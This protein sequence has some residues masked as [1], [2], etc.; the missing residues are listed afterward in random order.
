MLTQKNNKIYLSLIGLIKCLAATLWF[1]LANISMSLANEP[2]LV[3][4]HDKVR[5]PMAGYLSRAVGVP[6]EAT[7]DEIAQKSEKD[8]F[9]YLPRLLS[10]GYSPIAHWYRF[11]VLRTGNSPQDWVLA[12]GAPVINDI[13]VYVPNA[14]G[15]FDERKL[16]DHIPPV[17]RQLATRRHAATFSLPPDQPITI[18]VRLV[19]NS[20]LMFSAEIWQAEALIGSESTTSFIHGSYFGIL[21]VVILVYS[22]F[23]LWLKDG[24]LLGYVAYV[25]TLFIMNLGI[26]GFVPVI[27]PSHPYW[28]PDIVTGG[29]TL[30]SCI[31]PFLMWDR[32]LDMRKNFPRLHLIYMFLFFA[33]IPGVAFIRTD[34][35]GFFATNYPLIAIVTGYTSLAFTL[36]VIWRS[37]FKIILFLYFVAFFVAT[38]AGTFRMMLILGLV[39][40]TFATEYSFQ[41][42]SIV[43][44]LL[45]SLALAY[46]IREIDRD[47][48]CAREEAV[49]SARR[50]EEQ[51]QFVGMLSHEFRA[52]LANIDKATQM[53]E[54]TVKTMSSRAFEKLGVIRTSAKRLSSMVDSF[55]GAEALKHGNLALHRERV[56][57]SEIMYAALLRHVHD[58]I[59]ARLLLKIE[60]A[61]LAADLDR[62]MMETAISNLLDNA[63]RYSPAGTAIVVRVK[64]LKSGLAISI[65]DKGLGMSREEIGR[66]GTMYFR[67]Q[68][69][70]G[71][72]GSGLGLHMVKMIAAAHGG[73]C[74]IESQIG[75]GTIVT[76]LL[77][78]RAGDAK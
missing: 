77:P 57:L 49:I 46:R 24:A 62:D 43:H 67:A 7:I 74:E 12:L 76:L 38:T 35:Y 64:E 28:L 10:G 3:L 75:K 66:V 52:P 61:E 29:G 65:A 44:I 33:L 31:T 32:F 25:S 18:Y 17:E 19:S 54:L 72:K 14:Y 40:S 78:L 59:T 36:H 39:H 2:V 42:A 27:F 20:V 9:V 70:K 71:T 41:I 11:T 73:A 34:Y 63:L 13:R 15:G 16:G 53:I 55:L 21:A 56:K 26:N 8:R 50:A 37:G 58:G 30:L 69:A 1:F 23:G 48:A 5:V 60:P 68:S 51:R 45:L 22:L 4:D 47:R 6:L